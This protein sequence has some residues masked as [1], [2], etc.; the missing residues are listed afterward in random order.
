MKKIN[1]LLIAFSISIITYPQYSPGYFQTVTVIENYGDNVSNYIA[2]LEVNT[3]SP[4]T[5]GRMNSDGSDIRFG[6]GCTSNYYDYWIQSGINTSST[7]IFVKIPTLSANDSLI[8]LLFYGDSNAIVMSDFNNTFPDRFISSGNVNRSGIKNYGWVE[9]SAGDTLFM[10]NSALLKIRAAYVKIDGAIVGTA[11]GHSGGNPGPNNGSGAGGGGSSSNAGCG[12]GGYGGAGGGGGYDSGDSPGAGGVAN[13]TANSLD[14]GKG[15][16]GGAGS[17]CYGGDG[18]GGIEI[19][20]RFVSITGSII[21]DGERGQTPGCGQGGGGGA[22]GGILIAGDSIEVSGSISARGGNGSVGTSTLNDDGG[23]GGGGRIKIFHDA[24][25]TG[26][27]VRVVTGG[28]GGPNGSASGGANGVAGTVFD[29]TVQFINPVM[30]NVQVYPGPPPPTSAS[31]EICNGDSILLGGEYRLTNGSYT[32]TLQNSNGC[33]S[34]VVTDLTVNS[35]DTGLN[36]NGTNLSAVTSGQSYQWLKCDSSG[37]SI[38][39]GATSQSYVVTQ[40]GGYA[41]SVKIGNCIDTSSCVLVSWVGLEA[42]ESKKSVS[43]YPNPFRDEAT[44]KLYRIAKDV[45]IILADINGKEILISDFSNRQTILLNTSDISKGIYFLNV[46]YDN[47]IEILK[48]VKE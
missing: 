43:V 27:S 16:G 12:G 17:S 47:K 19:K 13:G 9:I 22:G 38:I 28:I 31:A 2:F 48:L 7:R 4:I 21:M 5:L 20:S 18:G 34:V 11:K 46:R 42:W 3:L 32:D 15:S 24:N 37:Y 8:I 45:H 36:I 25:Y 35:P 33:D 10:G 1:S 26:G 30:G 40:N 44:I 41:L 23:G 14:I 29:T 6:D 39:S